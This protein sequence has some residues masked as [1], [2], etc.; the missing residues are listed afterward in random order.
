M[1]MT[2]KQRAQLSAFIERKRRAAR[3]SK[4]ILRDEL[5]HEPVGFHFSP[6]RHRLTPEQC[7]LATWLLRR[8]QRRRPIRGA[9]KVQQFRRALRVSGIISAI[10]NNKVGNASWGR[11]MR[12][13]RGGLALARHTPQVLARNREG[14][15]A[16]RQAR[17]AS[18][19]RLSQPKTPF[20]AW[21]RSIT[22]GLQQEQPKDFMSW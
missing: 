21:Q 19:P 18:Q 11:S 8:A 1:P 2:R 7:R 3:H 12:A 13:K 16:R 15:L 20:E 9:G 17:K 14:I 22:A 6:Q 4:R 5:D 10:R